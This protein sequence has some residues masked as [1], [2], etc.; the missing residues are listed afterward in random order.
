VTNEQAIRSELLKAS[1]NRGEFSKIA[2]A[3]GVSPST[4]TRWIPSDDTPAPVIP[5]PMLKLLNLY[6][7]EIMPFDIAREKLLGSVLDFTE[8][9]YKVICVLATRQ[10]ST[11]AKWI[12]DKIRDYLV[13][14]DA[15]KAETSKIVAERMARNA[16]HL[17]ILPDSRV[18][19]EPAI[20]KL[21]TTDT[22][23]EA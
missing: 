14:N 3:L 23:K 17:Q 6:F 18:A 4:V 7:F 1:K 13:M 19:E 20:P 9:Q 8:D 11:P 5:P 22:E 10:S 16:T 12:S 2:K 15:A 21:E